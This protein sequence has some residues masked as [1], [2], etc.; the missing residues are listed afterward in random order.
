MWDFLEDYAR[1][2]KP[3]HLTEVT[4]LSS[5]PFKDWEDQQKMREL[6]RSGQTVEQRGSTPELEQYQASYLRDFYTLAFSHPSV[7]S[8][9]YWS[10]SDLNEWRGSAGGLL[11]VEHNPKPAYNTLK[12]LIKEKWHTRL[13][14]AIDT[15]GMITFNGFYGEYQ[16]IV[17]VN[18]K[19]HTF[20]FAHSSSVEDIHVVYLK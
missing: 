11:D 9:I 15:S 8:I 5:E 3:I 20:E 16:G 18:G 7:E 14:S 4:V 10:A 1:F 2:N 19:K 6:I 12:S 13:I 17:E